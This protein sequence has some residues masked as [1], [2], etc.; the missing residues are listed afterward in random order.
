MQTYACVQMQCYTVDAG[1][2]VR[3]MSTYT[4][5]QGEIRAHTA[6]SN[7]ASQLGAQQ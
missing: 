1:N 3:L 2:D 5:T 7:N 6:E 4:E